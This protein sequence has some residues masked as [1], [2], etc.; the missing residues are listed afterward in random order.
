MKHHYLSAWW[1]SANVGLVSSGSLWEV[2][3]TEP[4]TLNVEGHRSFSPHCDIGS[5]GQSLPE[6]LRGAVRNLGIALVLPG[7][8]LL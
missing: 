6:V 8:D 2:C 4:S 5:A 7:S 3:G 1:L